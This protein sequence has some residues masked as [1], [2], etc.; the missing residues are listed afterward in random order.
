MDRDD[1]ESVKECFGSCFDVQSMNS[2]MANKLSDNFNY[3]GWACSLIVFFFLWFSFGSFE[4]ALI[5][6]LPMA[7]SWL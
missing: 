1:L 4:L 2:A 7:L 5:S 3:I 6:F